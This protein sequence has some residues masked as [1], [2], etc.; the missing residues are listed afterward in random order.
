MIGQAMSE[1]AWIAEV[2]GDLHTYAVKNG[3]T[4]IANNIENTVPALEKEVGSV[5]EVGKLKARLD[6]LAA[7]PLPLF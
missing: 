2:L 5:V 1:H 6:A 4:E 7:A 3:L